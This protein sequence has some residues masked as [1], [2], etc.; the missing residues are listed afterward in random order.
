MKR[1][2]I[3]YHMYINHSKPSDNLPHNIETV[4]TC[5]TLPMKDEIAEDLLANGVESR[6]LRMMGD[7]RI[8]LEHISELQGYFFKGVYTI[9]EE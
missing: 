2:C 1:I 8:V 9:E 3:T 6:Y 5:I 4:E 7:V